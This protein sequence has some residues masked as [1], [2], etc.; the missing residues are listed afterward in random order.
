MSRINLLPPEIRKERANARLARRIR[1]G[2]LAMAALLFGIYGIRTWQVISMRGELQAARAESAAVQAQIDAFAE[3][4]AEQQ[5]I[6][7]A[8]AVVNA[9]LAG[10]VSWSEQMLTVAATVPSGFS[11]TSL[12]GT[13]AVQTTTS[14]IGSITWSGSSSG[15][16]QTEA[17][18][19][20]LDAQEGWAN[21]W[22]GSVQDSE[23]AVTTTGSVDLTSDAVT[24]R[25]G[26]PA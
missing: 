13:V 21:G 18:L 6:E 19:A 5:S 16:L 9:V 4:V 14:V 20:R 7:S 2:G 24:T 23:G 26:G 3:V 1:V 8:K 25:G 22:V 10:E 17:W 15:Y 12:S 11:L